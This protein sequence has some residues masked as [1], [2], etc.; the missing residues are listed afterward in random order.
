MSISYL[1]RNDFPK[2][3]SEFYS[4]LAAGLTVAIVALPL[5]IGFAVTT[6]MSA[7]SGIT[8]AI[9]AGFIAA[10][11][12][13]SRYQVSG[14]TGAMTVVLIPI[15][16]Q[17]GVTAIP[18]LGVM[19][20]LI[21]VIAAICRAGSIINRVPWAVVEGFT[22][23]IALVIA[24]QQIPLALD[25]PKGSGDRTYLVAWHTL[26]D[27]IDAGINWSSITAVILT[28]VV[29]FNYPKLA[30][31]YKFKV[32][33]P[34]SIV[35]ILIITAGSLAFDLNLN[36]IGDIPRSIGTW[37]VDL[38]ELNSLGHLILPAALIAI[39]AAI[40]SLLS[41]RV[42][43]G[44]VHAQGSE[45]Y[46]PNKELFG[47]GLATIGSSLFGG[48]PATG[49]IA[50]TSVNVRNHAKSRVASMAHAMILL[51]IVLLLAPV[52]SAI[53][54]A[55]I[56]GVLIG[57]SYRILNPASIRESLKTTYAEASVLVITASVTLLIDLI[58]GIGVG[59]VAHFVAKL[60]NRG[61]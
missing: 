13:G 12:G 29:K 35:A 53:P 5:A 61:R 24:L 21:V 49:A 37:S 2:S 11:F 36:S 32:H 27:A 59:I 52:V 4:D 60:V 51:L 40:E 48:M 39:L 23:G 45:K 20:G 56:A 34:A 28:L 10:L 25:I 9:I 33:I 54:T 58:W 1:S 22:V 19:A 17:Y 15:V 7:A 18:A 8:T 42:A 46:D 55:A 26:Q 30:H 6:G 44:M 16:T 38:I 57:T 43:D 47:Q 41:A 3:K 31:R 14:P 50:R